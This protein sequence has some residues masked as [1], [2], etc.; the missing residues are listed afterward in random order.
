MKQDV[1]FHG[2]PTK[3]NVRSIT[4][5]GFQSGTWFARHMEDAA[6]YGGKYVFSVRVSFAFDNAQRR[7]H[8][9]QVCCSNPLPPSTIR[10]MHLVKKATA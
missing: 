8:S 2:T 9:W 10:G 6:A 7:R 5:N 4:R 1:W 3:K